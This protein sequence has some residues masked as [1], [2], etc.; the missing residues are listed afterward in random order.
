M[1]YKYAP[2]SYSRLSLYEKCPAAF[3]F[4]YIDRVPELPP[5]PSLMVGRVI[6]KIVEEYLKELKKR[7]EHTNLTLLDVLFEKARNG[8]NGLAEELEAYKVGVSNVTLP[9]F[10]KVGIEVKVA[11]DVNLSPAQY[12]DK[13]FLRAKIDRVY[14]IENKLVVTDWKTDRHLPGKE[15][16]KKDTGRMFQ[17]DPKEQ[18][19]DLPNLLAN[20]KGIARNKANPIRTTFALLRASNKE[21]LPWSTCP[22]TVIIGGRLLKFSDFVSLILFTISSALFSLIGL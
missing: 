21:V 17:D 2:Y 16:I 5:G 4:R 9:T 7:R 15:V 8:L 19:K 14:Q 13:A 18:L 22:I 1:K 3:R 6:H 10:D 20:N 12:D 11:L